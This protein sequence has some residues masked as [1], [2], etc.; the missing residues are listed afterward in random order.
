[1]SAKYRKLTPEEHNHMI[2]NL[3][4]SVLLNVY[5]QIN[6]NTQERSMVFDPIVSFWE[7][8]ERLKKCKIGY[9]DIREIIIDIYTKMQECFMQ[10]RDPLLLSPLV[11]LMIIKFLQYTENA[12]YVLKFQQSYAD[13]FVSLL[14]ESKW[15]LSLSFQAISKALPTINESVRSLN[16]T[17]R[18]NVFFVVKAVDSLNSSDPELLESAIEVLQKVGKKIASLHFIYLQ[19]I[20]MP[21]L[22]FFLPDM[23]QDADLLSQV[24]QQYDILLKQ[25]AEKLSKQE[26]QL[27]DVEKDPENN[28]F[29]YNFY[30]QNPIFFLHDVLLSIIQF[31]TN[32]K[33]FPQQL[34]SSLMELSSLL[35]QSCNAFE[36]LEIDQQATEIQASILLFEMF[37][38]VSHY[39]KST[40]KDFVEFAIRFILKLPI[41]RHTTEDGETIGHINFDKSYL[42]LPLKHLS[43]LQIT[44]AR[45]QNVP[46]I[47][48]E[49]AALL[50]SV[51]PHPD[52]ND[53]PGDADHI[54]HIMLPFQNHNFTVETCRL[55]LTQLTDFL[56]FFSEEAHSII[57]ESIL[58]NLTKQG[59][60]HQELIANFI[61][62]IPLTS[63]N[64]KLLTYYIYFASSTYPQDV[65]VCPKL[66][67]VCMS[68]FYL[69]NTQPEPP[70]ADVNA[71]DIYE[72]AEA[73]FLI[74]EYD[75]PAILWK[76]I[77]TKFA[78]TNQFTKDKIRAS[79]AFHHLSLAE[80]H[81]QMMDHSQ[82]AR[83]FRRAIEAFQ[84]TD[85]PHDLH[86]Y[87]SQARYCFESICMQV[88]LMNAMYSDPSNREM[89]ISQWITD[90]EELKVNLDLL[91][92]SSLLLHPRNDGTSRRYV[93]HFIHI[94]EQMIQAIDGD[95]AT[96]SDIINRERILPP[97]AILSMK[98]PLFVEDLEITN[99]EI[100]IKDPSI[101]QRFYLEVTGKIVRSTPIINHI[102]YHNKYCFYS[103]EPPEDN[104]SLSFDNDAFDWMSDANMKLRCEIALCGGRTNLHSQEI[105]SCGEFKIDF[106]V[107]PLDRQICPEGCQ[108]DS[109]HVMIIKFS[110]IASFQ[111]DS[112]IQNY[113]ISFFDKHVT[114]NTPYL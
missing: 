38:Q 19:I 11:K 58:P 81:Y 104:L 49:S 101:A 50:I 6:D 80:K 55:F 33:T 75:Q 92:N 102:N 108:S 56:P 89:P 103:S 72:C 24:I 74:G 106:P 5:P 20:K 43:K 100:E 82:S 88:D 114:V 40:Q 23:T 4:N 107:L 51:C 113:L 67:A 79:E 36:Y 22:L 47:D 91:R 62:S 1:M 48:N 52:E 46:P 60:K 25:F 69:A 109:S 37:S 98:Q 54:I 32:L 18:S 94:S 59:P 93:Q 96:F 97:P 30:H 85:F 27:T 45:L 63:E 68:L 41:E 3:I 31:V 9:I 35:Y 14:P 53:S 44:D 110:F 95:P 2:Q 16:P 15:Q 17:I 77:Y 10:F 76:T 64:G 21:Y 71:N 28:N 86:I 87:Y 34:F 42:I 105:P 39:L 111:E 83:E 61:S 78:D 26:D 112:G 84:M 12:Q 57:L 66:K 7:L 29:E 73:L 70:F 13:R 65:P 90:I 8:P 99:P